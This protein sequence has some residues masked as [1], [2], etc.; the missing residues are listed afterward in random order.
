MANMV[1]GA[2]YRQIHADVVLPRFQS[3][4]SARLD[5]LVL[6][7]PRQTTAYL[8]GDDKH[9]DLHTIRIMD[10]W[11]QAIVH[12]GLEYEEKTRLFGYL[13]DLRALV[14]IPLKVRQNMAEP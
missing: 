11:N 13:C 4:S 6:S 7:R 1:S 9:Q 5:P 2:L 14:L 3:L 12:H 8:L 10:Y